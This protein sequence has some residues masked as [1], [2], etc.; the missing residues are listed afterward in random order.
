MTVSLRILVVEDDWMIG[1]LLGEMLESMG[2][3]VCAIEADAAKAVEAA[4]RLLPDMMLVDVRLG[5]SSGIAA[6]EEI[7]RRRFVPHVFVTGDSLQTLSLAREAVL[8]QK[9]FRERD[10]AQA[11]ERAVGRSGSAAGV[12]PTAPV[13]ERRDRRP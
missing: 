8:I 11:I 3:S 7:L 10:I 12:A 2:H 4:A 5:N 6:V 1:S 9:P 13:V